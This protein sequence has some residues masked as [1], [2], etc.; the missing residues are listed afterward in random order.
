MTMRA[1]A[2]SR[3]KQA[4]ESRI[5]TA[6]TQTILDAALEVFS[7][8]GFRGATVD[9]IAAKADMSKPNLL[10]YFRRKEDIYLALL[11]NTLADWLEPLKRLDAAGEPLAEIARYI[12]AKLKMSR[13][14]PKAS[15][16]FANELLQGAPAIG[17]F[18]S[19]PLKTL[20]DEKARLI[21]T[22]IRQGK[23]ASVDP[24]HLIFSIWAV[25]QTYAD[26]DVQIRA[27]VGNDARRFADAEETILAIVLN[28]LKPRP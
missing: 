9:Q 20:V 22:W 18:L 11:E 6:N 12:S 19:G 2:V 4:R 23:M 26:F 10:Y 24:Y 14:N 21:R 13:D 28:G 17:A 7:A 8:Y 5:R 25:T 15:R 3:A 16:L 27:I 1:M